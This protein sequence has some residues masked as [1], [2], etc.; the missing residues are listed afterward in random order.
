[1]GQVAENLAQV[2]ERI[3]AACERAGRD[4]AG[5]RLMAVSKTQPAEVVQEAY[6]AGLRLF[7]ENRVQE[8]VDKA[9]A[10]AEHPDLQWAMIGHL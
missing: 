1:M 5:V 3:A 7:G 10:L 2:R 6:D 8:A 4:P 9:A